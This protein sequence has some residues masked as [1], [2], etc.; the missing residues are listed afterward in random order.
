MNTVSNKIRATS[1]ENCSFL[2]LFFF[3]ICRQTD[4]RGE[5]CGLCARR[6]HVTV[7]PKH[8]ILL[9]FSVS[10]HQEA[11]EGT[12]LLS[13]S[14][15]SQPKPLPP[16]FFFPARILKRRNFTDLK[17]VFGFFF[18]C[19]RNKSRAKFLTVFVLGDALQRDAKEGG[20]GVVVPDQQLC[21][22]GDVHAR[23]VE[24]TG[25]E[26]TGRTESHEDVF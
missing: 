8:V 2:G 19:D 21:S 7:D 20:V 22:S 4:C 16:P 25:P 24:Y 3:F 26:R 17:D 15:R 1:K 13:P 23:S 10:L 5:G 6:L 18:F 14:V 9:S 11:A 12:W